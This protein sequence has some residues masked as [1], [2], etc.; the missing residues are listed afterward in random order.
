MQTIFIVIQIVQ[1]KI[2][3]RKYILSVG[4]NNGEKGEFV[5]M[6]NMCRTH[7][8][9]KTNIGKLNLVFLWLDPGND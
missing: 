5:K 1:L 4:P 9:K 6:P 7:K 2:G 3:T 8:Q